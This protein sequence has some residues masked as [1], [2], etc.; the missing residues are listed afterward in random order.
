MFERV[1]R[2]SPERA[3]EL[4]VRG[5]ERGTQRVRI[6]P[7]TYVGDWLK[8]LFPSAT[9]WWIRRAAASIPQAR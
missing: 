4:I 6:A 7:E 3:A 5:I 2:T 8:R 9:Q 1:A